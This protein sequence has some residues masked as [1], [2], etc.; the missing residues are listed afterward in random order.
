MTADQSNKLAC[1]VLELDNNPNGT[2]DLLLHDLHVRL[3]IGKDGGVDEVSLVS[4]TVTTKGDSGAVCLA[5][6]DV[7]HDALPKFM[8]VND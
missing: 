4:V 8:R 7:R 3:G 5:G 6:V 1:L 2:E